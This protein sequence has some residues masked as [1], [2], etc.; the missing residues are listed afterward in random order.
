MYLVLMIRNIIMF[1]CLAINISIVCTL[2][3][4]EEDRATIIV[5]LV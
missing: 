2:I 4:N 1:A 5:L 3:S